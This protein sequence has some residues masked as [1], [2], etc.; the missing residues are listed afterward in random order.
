MKSVFE[1]IKNTSK[2]N[3]KVGN[4][5]MS[6]EDRANIERELKKEDDEA[7][8]KSAIRVKVR[9]SW[10]QLLGQ[11]ERAKS[12]KQEKFNANVKKVFE[13]FRQASADRKARNKEINE[14][15]KNAEH[16]GRKKRAMR[17]GYKSGLQG[18]SGAGSFLHSI[19]GQGGILGNYRP[20]MQNPLA[21]SAPRT[22][23]RRTHHHRRKGKTRTRVRTVY[24]DRD[25][26]A[27]PPMNPFGGGMF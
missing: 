6:R 17:E 14:I 4:V 26:P 22:A 13:N 24:V 10:S 25:I 3:L 23:P 9:T 16:E 2:S 27:R 20:P 1:D 19:Y 18:G 5:S 15:R 21:P 7:K 11:K 8:N 12:E